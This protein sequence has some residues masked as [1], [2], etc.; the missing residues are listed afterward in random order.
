MHIR[1]QCL[2]KYVPCRQRYKC[3][4]HVNDPRERFICTAAPLRYIATIAWELEPTVQLCTVP[5]GRSYSSFA[6]LPSRFGHV[7]PHRPF[8]VVPR[9]SPRHTT[10][11]FGHAGTIQRL[12]GGGRRGGGSPRGTILD[13]HSRGRGLRHPHVGG[14]ATCRWSPI[15]RRG[16]H[17]A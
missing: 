16:H 10:R 15:G 13:V 17:R 14:R 7:G 3:S 6:F 11:K 4:H 2:G 8:S 1:D 12:G 9:P 5:H